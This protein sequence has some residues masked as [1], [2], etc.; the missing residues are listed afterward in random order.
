MIIPITALSNETRRDETK[1]NE[2]ATAMEEGERERAME[3][4]QTG[5]M[6]G[7]KEGME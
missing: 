1:R 6:E 2:T 5:R 7:R 3:V 4:E